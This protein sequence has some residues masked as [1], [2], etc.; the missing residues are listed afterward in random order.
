[1][2]FKKKINIA[3]YLIFLPIL[4]GCIQSTASLLG[5]TITVAQTGN[6]YQAGLSYVS[7][8][9]IKNELGKTPIELVKSFVHKDIKENKTEPMLI[10]KK[11]HN[12]EKVSLIF[13]NKNNNYDEFLIAVKKVLK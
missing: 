1:M 11:Q 2:K 12:R 10:K 6:I 13:E 8:D 9:I 4:N 3:C 7:S 5:P